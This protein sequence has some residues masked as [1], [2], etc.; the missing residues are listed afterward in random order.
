MNLKDYQKKAIR[1]LAEKA[2]SLLASAE[3]SNS[4]KRMVLHAPTGSGKTIMM[5]EFL[6]TL[7]NTH[8][9]PEFCCVW[10]APGTLH[11]QSHQ[12]IEKYYDNSRVLE[13]R[14]FFDLVGDRQIRRNEILFLNWESIR[15]DDNIIIRD[16]EREFNLENVLRRTQEDGLKIILVIDESHRDANTEISMDLVES[17]APSLAIEMSA[18]PVFKNVDELVRIGLEDVKQSGM[19]KNSVLLN[20][21]LNEAIEGGAKPSCHAESNEY[22]LNMA[23][24]KRCELADAFKSADA[25][26]NPLLC[27]QLP[28]TNRLQIDSRIRETAAQTLAK[29]GITVDNGK[30]AVYLS[31]ERKNLENVSRNDNSVE[32]L[33]F[34]QAI[35]LGW[36]CPR[37]HILVLF[38]EWKSASF[39][40]Q[41]LGR[42][43]RMPEPHV[44]HY[45]SESNML[46]DAYV[47]TNL[48][49]VSIEQDVADKYVRLHSA[50]RTDDYTPVKLRSVHRIRE[51]ERTRLSPLFV[52]LFLQE[53]KKYA[54][55]EK[56]DMDD[57]TVKASLIG[58]Y[59]TKSVEDLHGKTI[60]GGLAIDVENEADLQ[61]LLEYFAADNISPYYP[62]SRSISRVRLAIYE[63]FG[64]PLE[65]NYADHFG[66]IVRTVLSESNHGHFVHVI[67]EAKK[68]YEKKTSGPRKPLQITDEWEVPTSVTYSGK[69]I[70]REANKSMMIPFYVEREREWKTEKSFISFLEQS[71]NVRQWYKNGE[72]D[73]AY[74]AVSYLKD[75]EERPFYVD[76]V[77]Q[78]NDGKIGLYDTKIGRTLTDG[79]GPKSD[80]LLNYIANNKKRPLIGGI[81][82]P[83][84]PSNY[85]L[86]WK[87]YEGKGNDITGDDGWK[88]LIL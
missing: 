54:L 23:L 8:N 26:V 24:K 86:G 72:G 21:G 41:T 87:I 61:Y 60:R 51:R 36:D 27:I 42:I 38:R 30:L 1:S 83:S 34:K 84:N 71:K 46:N 70:K 55:K 66:K 77:V 80:G 69:Y 59:Y 14:Y 7:A 6:A 82:K 78:F 4:M 37:A 22:I 57:Q 73:S 5:A 64:G 44:G 79:G 49:K 63:F 56:I 11:K 81:V 13:C 33:I 40:V 74:F 18:T 67:N 88:P 58:S 52:D 25:N 39:S 76:F 50:H 15:Q 9:M 28:N 10:L 19:I 68:E 62:E 20:N 35:A 48:P 85:E 75:G 17:I 12:K 65:M 31:G 45:G 47:Y 53:A 29:H 3:S 2:Q 32:A 16:N 43:M